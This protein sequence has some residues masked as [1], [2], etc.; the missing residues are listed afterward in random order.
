MPSVQD[1]TGNLSDQEGS[2]TGT[3]GGG[4]VELEGQ[5]VYEKARLTN[6]EVHATGRSLSLRYPEGL[7]SVVDA[8]L[9]F[10]GVPD[11][12]TGY[13]YHL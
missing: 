8:D 9:R 6:F 3:V 7:R 11:T 4:P 12:A 5:A 1:R 2:L 10:F 13:Q